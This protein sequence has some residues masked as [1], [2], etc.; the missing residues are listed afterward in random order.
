MIDSSDVLRA[1]RHVDS[2][3][4]SYNFLKSTFNKHLDKCEQK[5]VDVLIDAYD[6]YLGMKMELIRVLREYHKQ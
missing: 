3:L 6:S 2:A 1:H 5:H 4:D